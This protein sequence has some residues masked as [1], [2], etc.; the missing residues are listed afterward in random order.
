MQQTN[1]LAILEL[2]VS[3]LASLGFCHLLGDYT[4]LSTSQMLSAKRF[5][6]PLFPIFVHAMVHTLLM[7]Y[8]LKFL[9]FDD[10]VIL[11]MMAL[12]CISHF[13]IDVLKGK[14]NKWFPSVQ[15]PINKWHWVIFGIDQYMHYLVIV[16]MSVYCVYSNYNI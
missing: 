13:L 3:T 14:M 1:V 9:G 11:K 8:A 2:L 5:G 6:T 7:G 10:W 12:Q 4:H 16:Y 15:S